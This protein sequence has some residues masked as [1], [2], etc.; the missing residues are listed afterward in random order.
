MQDFLFYFLL[1]ISPN[2][3]NNSDTKSI[4]SDTKSTTSE[5][6][7][8]INP[9][10]KD[11][12]NSDALFEGLLLTACAARGPENFIKFMSR[13]QVKIFNFLNLFF[14]F[15]FYFNFILLES[16]YAK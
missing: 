3:T 10:E 5:N 2:Q 6:T 8:K 7:T 4:S 15:F 13:Y 11:R 12:K 14:Y 1:Q 16:M 9:E